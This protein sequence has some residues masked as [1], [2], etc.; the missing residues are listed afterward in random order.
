MKVAILILILSFAISNIA[1]ISQ[2]VTLKPEEPYTFTNPLL[3]A[4]SVACKV[5]STDPENQVLGK[6]TKGSATINGHDLKPG[7]EL[8]V[9]VHNGDT[10]NIKAAK[11][12]SAVL[13]NHGP[14][15]VVAVCELS[16]QTME[17]IAYMKGAL[18]MATTLRN[19]K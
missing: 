17:E 13:T 7:D 5:Q 9:P 2:T 8:T 4:V 19:L 16:T 18:E 6:V 3:W 15:T 12:T 10:L 11:S 14:N 1:C